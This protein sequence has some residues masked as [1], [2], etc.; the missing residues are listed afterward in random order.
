MVSSTAIYLEQL[1]LV[2]IICLHTVKWFPVLIPYTTNSIQHYS[3]VKYTTDGSWKTMRNT[4]ILKY[5]LIF[6]FFDGGTCMEQ[7]NRV[8]TYKGVVGSRNSRQEQTSAKILD[9][10]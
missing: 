8:L 2:L 6:L 1:Y 3:F 4:S 9:R 10:L 7:E 5:N